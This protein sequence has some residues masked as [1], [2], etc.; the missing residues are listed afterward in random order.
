MLFNEY[1]DTPVLRTYYWANAYT[2][3]GYFQKAKDV[4]VKDFVRRFSGKL[5]VNRQHDISYCFVVSSKD[6][7]V[8]GQDES[9]KSIRLAIKK[10]LEECGIYTIMLKDKVDYSK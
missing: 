6:W 3:I 9:Y 10:A 4:T 5:I 8:Y 1:G 7:N 2:T